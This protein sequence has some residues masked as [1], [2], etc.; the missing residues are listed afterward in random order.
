MNAIV[1]TYLVKITLRE[2]DEQLVEEGLGASKEPTLDQLE[3]LIEGAIEL[4][5]TF[6]ANASASRTDS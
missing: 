3:K 6:S 1:A 5:T 2:T 4:T